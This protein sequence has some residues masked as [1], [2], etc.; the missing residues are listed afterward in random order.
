MERMNVGGV[1]QVTIESKCFSIGNS[2]FP[3]SKIKVTFFGPEDINDADFRI[4]FELQE[5]AQLHLIGLK[6]SKDEFM[7]HLPSLCL[8]SGFTA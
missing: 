3:V 8:P 5:G 2:Y 1:G 4:I 6:A 7:T